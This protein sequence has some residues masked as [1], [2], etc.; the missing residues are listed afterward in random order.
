MGLFDFVKEAGEKI[1]DSVS[2]H[3]DAATKIQDHLKKLGIPDADK[4]Q[5]NVD[6]DK[7]TVNGEGLSQ[8]LKEKILVAVGNVAG[9]SNVEDNVKTTDATAE[10]KFYTV[11]SGD[12]LSAIAK[13][14][15]G[16]ANQYNKIFE[17]NKPMLSHP[18]KIYPGQSLRIPA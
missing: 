11:K 14:V 1:W 6:G 8:E 9:I 10:S 4:V 15:Y 12:T 5:V 3:D 17:A 2:S 7:A 16:D 18:D 13:Q